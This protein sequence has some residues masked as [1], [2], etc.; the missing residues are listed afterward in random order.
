M[1]VNEMVKCL[2]LGVL[3]VSCWGCRANTGSQQLA[4][5][6]DSAISVTNSGSDSAVVFGD[7][8]VWKPDSLVRRVV[9]GKLV[10][11]YRLVWPAFIGAPPSLYACLDSISPYLRFSSSQPTMQRKLRDY[12]DEMRS[13]SA[14]L[15]SDYEGPNEMASESVYSVIQ[16]DGRWLVVATFSYE[17]QGG[18]HGSYGSYHHTV[19]IPD[20][21][22]LHVRDLFKPGTLQLATEAA[23]PFFLKDNNLDAGTPLSEHG[24]WFENDKFRLPE[25]FLLLPQHI[26]FTY[27]LYEV[28]PYV[29]GEVSFRVPL[30]AVARYLNPRL[31][32]AHARN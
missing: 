20:A 6:E 2:A 32:P 23:L 12:E 1:V 28:A 8:L 26:E 22:L 21:K 14:E 31:F 24:F 18:A 27:G 30:S 29:M 9:A 19:F 25:H 3:C 10:G 5:N 4:A 13:M 7:T 11:N 16:N 15:G 17:Y